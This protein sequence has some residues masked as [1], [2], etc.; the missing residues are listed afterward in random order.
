VITV[1]IATY[2]EESWAE[3][4]TQRALPSA[5]AQAEEVLM[6]HDEEGTIAGARNFLALQASGDLL[7]FLDAD[8]EL[9]PGYI[10]AIER[11]WA[12]GK[13]KLPLFTPIVQRVVNG[14]SKRA[15]FYKEV[16]L[17]GANWLVV[18]TVLE[19]ELFERVGGFEDYPHGF[20]D[21]SLWYKC[22]RVGATVV[23]VRDAVYVQ[24]VNPDS[25]HRQGWRN[26]NWQLQT[27]KRVQAELE[28]WTP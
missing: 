21:W 22:A 9:A 13:V 5:R 23:K 2:G 6:G 10:E 3:L 16:N 4:A 27:H 18:G 17:L 15:T 14:R 25:K 28:A 8:D 7:C 20:E 11:A 1:V 24:H 19:R 12:K 26:G